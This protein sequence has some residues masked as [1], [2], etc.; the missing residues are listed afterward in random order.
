MHEDGWVSDSELLGNQADFCISCA[1]MLRIARIDEH[2]SWCGTQLENE[3]AAETSGWVYFADEIGAFH[4][5]CPGCLVGRFG[6][7]SR[8]K[9][10]NR[11]Q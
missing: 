6:I 4:A 2:C 9:R 7:A 11:S 8:A 10:R 5:C 1:H 3:D